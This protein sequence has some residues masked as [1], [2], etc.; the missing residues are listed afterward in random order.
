M[1]K[2]FGGGTKTKTNEQFDT[3]PSKFQQP[4]LDSAFSAAQSD[5]N[6][7]K[8][9]PF[10]QGELYAGMNDADRGNLDAMR[11]YAGTQGLGAA[12]QLSQIGSNLAG[13]STQAGD[14]LSR[15]SGELDGDSTQQTIDSANRYADNPY[16]TGQIDAVSRDV[17]RNLSE[18]QLPG[19]D[20]AASGTGN[21]NSSRAGVA[22]GIAQRGAADRV[23]DISSFMRGDAYN[24]GLSLAQQDRSSRMA[25]LGSL[26]G[27]YSDLSRTGIGAIG[28]GA[29]AGYDAL[30][31]II[32]ADQL[33]QEDRQGVASADL[34]RWQG[35]DTRNADLLSRYYGVV[36]GNQWGQSGVSSGSSVQKKNQGILSGIIGAAATAASFIPK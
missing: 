35:Q 2:L 27:A 6:V 7:S 13:Y 4:Y 21:I 31:R 33:G 30:G 11:A 17:S 16:L 15:L 9:T 29:S 3:G 19:I 14:T 26:A 5:F 28:A 36:G 22:S 32:S 25:G 12:S 34:A 20:R 23:A 1:G 18:Q 8:G 24:R 10:Y